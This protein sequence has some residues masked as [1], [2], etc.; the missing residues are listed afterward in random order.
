MRALYFRYWISSAWWAGGGV[1]SP[2]PARWRCGRQDCANYSVGALDLF[3]APAETTGSDTAHLL[4]FSGSPRV[5]TAALY[6]L[7]ALFGALAL[8]AAAAGSSVPLDLAA[9]LAGLLALALPLRGFRR[10]RVVAPL[11]WL[12]AVAWAIAAREDAINSN[13][14]ELIVLGICAVALL[15]LVAALALLGRRDQD[16]GTQAVSLA[17]VFALACGLLWLALTFG[18]GQ[19]DPAVTTITL[20]LCVGTLGGALASAVLAGLVRGVRVVKHHREFR[21]PRR[22]TAP[23]LRA[24]ATPPSPA[25]KGFAAQTLYVF[26][27]GAARVATA[28][29]NALNLVLRLAY[30]AAEK[31]LLALALGAHHARRVTV[32]LAKLLAAATA[33]AAEILRTA[34]AIV[35]RVA[36]DWLRMT[37]LALAATALA[38]QGAIWACSLFAS[39][40]G[41]A[42]VLDAAAAILLA[43]ASGGV[44]VLVWWSLNR[45]TSGEVASSALRSA[46]AIGPTMFLTLVA[47]GWIDGL[48]GLLGYGP[49][50]PGYLTFAGTAVLIGTLVVAYRNK[51]AVEPSPQPG[52]AG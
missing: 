46:E 50:R 43:L 9:A 22:L 21:P 14:S 18:L 34:T 5:Q 31:L 6:A 12:G 25:T 20:L 44:C 2:E 48:I 15:A 47:L 3:C 32:W 24:P 37:V 41:G 39:Y 4:A 27:R 17:L 16:L 42:S 38:A 33:E 7:R 23:Q 29:A 11:L 45:Q 36:V 51:G 13:V 35:R 28:L 19:L 10:A 1:E 8:I 52:D 40:L 30:K 26:S 49:I